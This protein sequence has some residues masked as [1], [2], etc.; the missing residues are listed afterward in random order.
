MANKAVELDGSIV[1]K[2]GRSRFLRANH[3][4]EGSPRKPAAEGGS[5][6]EEEQRRG[7][8]DYED[9]GDD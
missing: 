4:G 1:E 2:D 8:S 6:E 7:Y 9:E 3:M 5:E